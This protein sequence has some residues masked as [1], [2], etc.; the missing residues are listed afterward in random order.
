MNLA[1]CLLHPQSGCRG[2]IIIII[3]NVFRVN[4]LSLPRSQ[5]TG[6]FALIGS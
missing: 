6:L 4:G 2:F 3:N 1:V 5:E